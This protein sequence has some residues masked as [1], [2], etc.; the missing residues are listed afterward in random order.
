[1]KSLRKKMM[2][3]IDKVLAQYVSERYLRELIVEWE[4]NGD[5]NILKH[6]PEFVPK[7]AFTSA[8]LLFMQND[9]AW[10]VVF[11]ECQENLK[12]DPYKKALSREGEEK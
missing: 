12:Q 9:P 7:S 10:R 8:Q 6:I 4:R 3:S 5:I 11:P 2:D 1:M